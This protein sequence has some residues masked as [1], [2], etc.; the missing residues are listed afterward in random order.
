MKK[1]VL[2]EAIDFS[3][4]ALLTLREALKN[5]HDEAAKW[6]HLYGP[7]LTYF[8]SSLLMVASKDDIDLA[9][10]AEYLAQFKRHYKQTTGEEWVERHAVGPERDPA[11]EYVSP[12]PNLLREE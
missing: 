8:F 11:P 4:T 7:V 9:M 1:T 12:V 2:M 5:G 6:A 10:G 3:R